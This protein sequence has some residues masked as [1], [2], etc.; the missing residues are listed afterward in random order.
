MG[1]SV[2]DLPYVTILAPR[3]FEVAPRIF[4]RFVHPV[5]I[6]IFF[7]FTGTRVCTFTANTDSLSNVSDITQ[8]APSPYS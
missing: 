2:C 5:L 6:I 3:V 4:G 8:L 7:F 1:S